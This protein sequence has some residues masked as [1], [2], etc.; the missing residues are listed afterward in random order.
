M[1]GYRGEPGEGC[2]QQADSDAPFRP[3]RTTYPLL[4]HGPQARLRQLVDDLW[5][6]GGGRSVLR[7]YKYKADTRVC[8]YKPTEY[9]LAVY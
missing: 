9:P 2:R 6:L 7:P 4:P 3:R 1:W 8:P 5:I